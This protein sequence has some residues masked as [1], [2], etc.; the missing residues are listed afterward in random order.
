M[1]ASIKPCKPL[2]RRL[3][4][5]FFAM[6]ASFKIAP[7]RGHCRRPRTLKQLDRYSHP[8]EADDH[9]PHD[10]RGEHRRGQRE[11]G[12]AQGREIDAGL[13]HGTGSSKA[14]QAPANAACTASA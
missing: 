11:Q 13:Y 6:T 12:K 5:A 10:H 9:R 7:R 3:A 8:L 4:A 14:E 1:E 2:I